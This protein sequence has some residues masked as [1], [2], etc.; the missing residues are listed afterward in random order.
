MPP[1]VK[2]TK[3]EI[4]KEALNMIRE[5]SIQRINARDLAHRLN[6]SVQPIFRSYQNM[7]NL[8]QTL[9]ETV[10]VI[11]DSHMKE[12]MTKHAIPFLGIGL[13][14]IDFAKSEKN[15]FKFLFMQDGFKGINLLDMIQSD[16][17]KEIINIIAAMTQL[18]IKQSEQLFLSIWLLTHGI[19]SLI[20]S[21]DCNL[22][23]EEIEKLLMDSFS[24]MKL[25]LKNKGE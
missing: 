9:Y 10:E 21:N 18:T 6:C 5:E 11:F 1:R 24:G 23:D 3:E 14:Y 2:V 25:Q 17:N 13:A 19:A 20:A 22:Q 12:G 7:E 8:K 15:Y 16:V 4:L